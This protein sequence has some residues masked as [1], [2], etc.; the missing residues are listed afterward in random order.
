MTIATNTFAEA[1][2][3][4]CTIEELKYALKGE[5]DASDMRE[6]CITETEWREQIE[7]AIEELKKDAAFESFKRG[8]VETL[9]KIMPDRDR[10]QDSDMWANVNEY[11]FQGRDILNA[12]AD[13][14]EVAENA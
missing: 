10:D 2:Y 5:A 3:D 6:W 12:Y 11:D 8:I 1:C 7:L 4:H 13:G 14:C 9:D